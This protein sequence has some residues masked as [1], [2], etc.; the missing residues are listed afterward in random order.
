MS[1]IDNIAKRVLRKGTV[2]EKRK[3]AGDTYHLMLMSEE[4]KDLPY[5]PGEQVKVYI[6]ADN[7]LS[8]SDKMRTYSIW[9]YEPDNGV[10]D[11]AI[12]TFSN[13]PGAEWVK[14]IR[15]CDVVYFGGMKG[16]RQIDD[17][18]DY[19]ILVGDVSSLPHLYELNR[20]LSANKKVY[21]F[22]HSEF[23][24]DFFTDVD[25]STPLSFYTMQS[26]DCPVKLMKAIHGIIEREQGRGVAYLEGEA[27]VCIAIHHYLK[28]HEQW[29]SKQIHTKPFWSQGKKGLD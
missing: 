3:I 17:S 20:H 22:I 7:D 18:A 4:L 13:G 1:I 6:G 11:L 27:E 28:K 16:K 26:A 24:E 15:E 25:G 29:Q 12:S 2:I 14:N 19:Y 8:F 10:I 9:N 5:A 23:H 21:S